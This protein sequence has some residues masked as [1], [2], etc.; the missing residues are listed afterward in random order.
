MEKNLMTFAA[1]Y[2]SFKSGDRSGAALPSIL[3]GIIDVIVFFLTPYSENITAF[4]IMKKSEISPLTRKFHKK[5]GE[6]YKNPL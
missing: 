2:S 4:C 3:L 5:K 1:Q 6:T